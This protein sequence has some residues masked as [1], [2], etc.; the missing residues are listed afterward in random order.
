MCVCVWRGGG[1]RNVSKDYVN[2]TVCVCVSEWLDLCE[3][4]CE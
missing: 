3:C 1:L 2:C 4:G